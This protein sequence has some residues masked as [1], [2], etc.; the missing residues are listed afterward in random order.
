MYLLEAAGPGASSKS[1]P[2]RMVR[3]MI[4]LAF[5]IA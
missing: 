4:I 2:P 1:S 3:Q 5:S